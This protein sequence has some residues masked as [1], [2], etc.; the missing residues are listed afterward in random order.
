MNLHEHLPGDQ[1]CHLN[2]AL[3]TFKTDLAKQAIPPGI[4]SHFPSLQLFYQVR[5]PQEHCKFIAYLN[6]HCLPLV[7]KP[8][9]TGTPPRA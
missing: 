5:I 9:E 4:I 3:S 8:L 7:D 6:A 2:K 1:N